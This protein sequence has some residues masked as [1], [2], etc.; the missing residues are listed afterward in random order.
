MYVFEERNIVRSWP[1]IVNLLLLQDTCGGVE[2]GN[3]QGFIAPFLQT[4]FSILFSASQFF[5]YCKRLLGCPWTSL[6]FRETSQN[7][8]LFSSFRQF[9]FPFFLSVVWL[10]GFTKFFFKQMLKISAF[11]LEKQKSF[12]LFLKKYDLKR[13]L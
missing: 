2:K 11:Y 12:I 1:F 4:F 7:F 6:Y 13:S 9:L 5:M 8:N 10:W 3:K